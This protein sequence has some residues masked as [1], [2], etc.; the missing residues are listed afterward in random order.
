MNKKNFSIIF[1]DKLYTYKNYLDFINKTK[2]SSNVSRIALILKRTPILLYY[3]YMCI[4]KG[5][6]FIPIDP[7]YPQKRIEFIIKESEPDLIISDLDYDVKLE[8]KY[9]NSKDDISYIIYTS[10]STGTPKGVEITRQ[11]LNNFIEG[12]SDIIDFSYGKRIACLTNVSFDIFLLESI[13]ALKKGLTVVL[14]NENEQN[15]PKHIANLIQSN[16]IDMIQMTPSKMQLLLNYDKELKCL[17]NVKEILIG[18]EVFPINLLYELQN[19]TNSKIYNLYGPT[20]ATIWATIS[21]L[22]YKKQIDIGFPIKNTQI[23]IIDENLNI[24]STGCVGEICI[25]GKGLARGYVKQ[26]DLTLRNFIYLPHD[27]NIRIYRTGDMGRIL[28]DGHL[29]FL[30]RIDN[31]VKIHGYRIELEEIESL[32]MQLD[33][34]KQAI[35]SIRSVGETNM[36]LEAFYTSSFELAPNYILNHL[37][38]H[39]PNYMLPTTFKRVAEFIRTSNDKIDRNKVYKCKVISDNNIETSDTNYIL[40]EYQQKIYRIILSSFEEKATDISLDTYFNEIGIDSINFITLILELE[41]EFHIEWEDEM[42]LLSSFSTIKSMV[43]Y[44]ESR[45]IKKQ[46]E[47]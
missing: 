26:K 19:K 39:L 41:N 47:K 3:I 9:I 14:A 32:M 40:N 44:V 11:A 21:E 2:I 4:D 8:S 46:Y 28:D 15:N 30:G 42:L 27:K 17:T 22:T 34:V 10:G 20:E 24:L 5:I 35:V 18:G 12:V 45:I 36:V 23:Y 25:A 29:E 37:A 43:D 33:G 38:D 1:N 7:S 6:T 31:Q 16:S 13:V